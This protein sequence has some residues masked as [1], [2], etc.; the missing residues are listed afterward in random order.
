MKKLLII[1]I[2]LLSLAL[3]NFASDDNL[4]Y[5]PKTQQWEFN[6]K[7]TTFEFEYDENGKL[8]KVGDM[9]VSYSDKGRI[10]YIGDMKVKYSMGLLK[11]IGKYVFVYDYKNKIR[12]IG[13][14]NPV[15]NRRNEIIQV[16]NYHIIYE[17]G[18]PYG[19][20]IKKIVKY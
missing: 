20:R 3:P 10:N 18:Y 5:N 2:A 16:G 13:D 14:Y 12:W 4:I 1:I 9:K 19:S 8:L 6:Y 11:S 7:E 17:Y 15:Y